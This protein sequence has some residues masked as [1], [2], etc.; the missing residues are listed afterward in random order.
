MGDLGTLLNGLNLSPV[1]TVLLGLLLFVFKAFD[2]RLKV[3]ESTVAKHTVSIA[4]IK[5]RLNIEEEHDE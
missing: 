5:E 2:T 4:V 3:L 1:N